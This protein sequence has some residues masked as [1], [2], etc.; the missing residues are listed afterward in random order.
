MASSPAYP[1]PPWGYQVVDLHLKP[2]VIAALL[3]EA[4]TR[5]YDTVFK[6]VGG[7][8]DDQFRYQS[9]LVKPTISAELQLETSVTHVTRCSDR[10]WVPSVFSYMMSLPGGLEQDPH[11]DSLKRDFNRA[12]S[13]H[14]NGTPSSNAIRQH[15][16]KCK[17]KPNGLE[18]RA[19]S[20]AHN[21]V[22]CTC[23][24]CGINFKSL[25]S[26]KAHNGVHRIQ[27]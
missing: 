12:I 24:I 7:K 27:Q 13:K 11:Q 17:K 20:N 19:K 21:Q 6:E 4:K 15:R 26:L 8:D 23:L 9:R 16:Y 22:P 3:N 1:F 2:T 18:T 14:P 5:Q 10:E 25:S